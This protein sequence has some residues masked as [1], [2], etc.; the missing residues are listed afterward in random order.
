MLVAPV[1]IGDDAWTGAGSTITRDVS[2]GA[3]GVERSVQKEIPDYA[4]R[5]NAKRPSSE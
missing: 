4:A 1:E 5:R 2:P 3:L